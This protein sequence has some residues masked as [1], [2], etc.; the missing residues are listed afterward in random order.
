MP[1]PSKPLLRAEI[2]VQSHSFDPKK[3][4]EGSGSLKS[5]EGTYYGV[6]GEAG[7]RLLNQF[8]TG[9]VCVIEYT[10]TPRQSGGTWKNLKHKVSSTPTVLAKPPIQHPRPRTNPVD[11]EQ[12]FVVGLLKEIVTWDQTPL[13]LVEKVNDFRKVWRNTFGGSETNRDDEMQDEI[14][15]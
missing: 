12:M 5:S 15:Y 3:G 2:T 10:E 8:Q 13:E 14:P 7:Q 4:K 6:F 9:E 11:Q 1:E